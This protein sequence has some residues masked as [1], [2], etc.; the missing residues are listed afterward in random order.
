MD[1]NGQSSFPDRAVDFL[2]PPHSPPLWGPHLLIP[3]RFLRALSARLRIAN[4]LK[5]TTHFHK[6]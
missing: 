1:Q 3:N 2:F 6:H 5:L 4:K